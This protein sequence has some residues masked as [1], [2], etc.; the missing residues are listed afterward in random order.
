MGQKKT[1]GLAVDV[2]APAATLIEFGELYRIDNWNG[3]AMDE[4]TA[5]EEARGLALDVSLSIFYVK[6]PSGLTAARGAI[7]S[8]AGTDNGAYRTGQTHLVAYGAATSVGP[9]AIV[10]EAKDANNYAGVRVLN[11]ARV[12][13]A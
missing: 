6:V 13:V 10:E 4:I 7:L 8:W 5:T 1:D 11:G 12:A 3:F 9:C 2:S